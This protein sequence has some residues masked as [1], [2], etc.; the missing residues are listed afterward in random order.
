MPHS[1]FSDWNCS[2]ART[3]DVLR[4]P[5]TT[6]ILRD[7]GIGISR[8]SRIQADLGISRRTLAERLAAL[9]DQGVVQRAAYQEHPPRYDYHLT[10]KGVELAYVLLAMQAWGDRWTTDEA[11]PPIVW[12]HLKCGEFS[13]P[14]LACSECG[15]PLKAGEAVPYL[16]PGAEDGVPGTTEVP[17]AIARLHEAF[18]IG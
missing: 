18:G 16:G 14:T 7:I 5:W 4:D 6:L 17:A 15:E 1:S 2:V 11:G 13:T 12:K 10:A 3:L 9:V 8:F